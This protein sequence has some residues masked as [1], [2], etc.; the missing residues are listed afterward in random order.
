MN[1]LGTATGHA[2]PDVP[3]FY[4][5]VHPTYKSQSNAQ[6][7]K[8][9]RKKWIQC[10]VKLFPSIVSAVPYFFCCSILKNPK[11]KDGQGI[12]YSHVHA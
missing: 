9:Y 5:T 3:D 8:M 6:N 12:I 7:I 2:F 1:S 11:Q 4:C 10:T